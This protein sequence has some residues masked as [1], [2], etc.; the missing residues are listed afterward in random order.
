[1]KRKSR[2]CHREHGRKQEK[3]LAEVQVALPKGAEYAEARGESEY[4]E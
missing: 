3:E 1:M 2:I 4:G